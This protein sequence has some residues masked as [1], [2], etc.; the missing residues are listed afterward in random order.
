VGEFLAYGLPR[1][2]IIYVGMPGEEEREYIRASID[3]SKG[4]PARARR[5]V[6]PRFPEYAEHAKLARP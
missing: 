5:L 2:R 1:R 3:A 4:P 6:R